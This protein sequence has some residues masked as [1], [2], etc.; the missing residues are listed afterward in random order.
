VQRADGRAVVLAFRGTPPLDLISW[1]VDADV[2]PD[3]VALSSTG[4]ASRQFEVQC[5]LLP[6]RPDH[7]A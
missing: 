2:Y 5:R 6:Q 1:F 4:K 7:P 3:Q